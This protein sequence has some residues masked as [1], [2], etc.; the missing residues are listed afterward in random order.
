MIHLQEGGRLHTSESLIH[1]SRSVYQGKDSGSPMN[2]SFVNDNEQVRGLRLR[3]ISCETFN[4]TLHRK[5]SDY[6]P[7]ATLDVTLP[8]QHA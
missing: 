1:K 7:T 3:L 5:L 8:M 2:L 6:D 4:P